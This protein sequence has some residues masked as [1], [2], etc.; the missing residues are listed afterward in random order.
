MP[1]TP[2]PAVGS[3]LSLSGIVDIMLIDK[4]TKEVVQHI[5][6]KNQI[7]EAFARWILSGNL[8]SPT[9]YV[10]NLSTAVSENGISNFLGSK[11]IPDF[12]MID[13]NVDT[14][15]FGI[16]LLD[17]AAPVYYHT[18]I[19]P[20]AGSTLMAANSSVVF[21]GTRTTQNEEGATQTMAIELAGSKWSHAGKVPGFTTTYLRTEGEAT[22]SSIILGRLPTVGGA[23]QVRQSPAVM[24]AGWDNTWINSS[25]ASSSVPRG[26]VVIRNWAVNPFASLTL[27]EGR[28]GTGLYAIN[29]AYTGYADTDSSTTSSS[30][31]RFNY[32]DLASKRFDNNGGSDSSQNFITGEVYSTQPNQFYQQ[33]M[34]GGIAIGNHR[35]VKVFPGTTEDNQRTLYVALQTAL[36]GNSGKGY[37]AIH[38][39]TLYPSNPS[40]PFADKSTGG[41]GVTGYAG[42]L[43]NSNFPVMVPVPGDSAEGDKIEV[44]LTLGMGD[45]NVGTAGS[46]S[47]LSGFEIVKVTLFVGELE[48]SNG[49]IIQGMRNG[50]T[51]NLSSMVKVDYMYAVCPYAIGLWTRG[52]ST[53]LSVNVNG[54]NTSVT[55]I[56]GIYYTHGYFDPVKRE[57]YLPFT[58][59]VKGMNPATWEVDP[60]V[61]LSMVTCWSGS[62]GVLSGAVFELEDNA[63]ISQS[64]ARTTAAAALNRA[65][66]FL[67]SAGGNMILPCVTSEGITPLT[68]NT[69]QRR[70]AIMSRVMSGVLLDQ[71]IIKD[72]TQILVVQYSYLFD[73][74]PIRP[75]APEQFEVMEITANSLSLTWSL[76]ANETANP[77]NILLQYRRADQTTWTTVVLRTT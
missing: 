22:I 62:Q 50:S 47:Y 8:G 7:T 24:P 5:R 4:E 17:K 56:P 43:Y 69:S 15:N 41:S 19:T 30:S 16:Y 68:V 21:Y 2:S 3:A 26:E 46:P 73:I 48:D 9:N 37:A 64:A 31:G 36:T 40:T 38:T 76:A 65:R 55:N 60:D 10:R 42:S 59:L 27:V 33:V 39:V 1:N 72:P 29:S 75:M 12:Q 25:G 57:Y 6:K 18:Q 13:G 53:S 51:G 54:S 34:E 67:F 44:F 28:K 45:Y 63:S 11:C 35:L 71:P 20:Y 77:T 23:I 32:Y 14:D 61:A 74:I 49:D 66:D 52:A 70:T 58:H